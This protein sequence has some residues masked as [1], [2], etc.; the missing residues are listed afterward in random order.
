[1]P[2]LW[3]RPGRFRARPLAGPALMPGGRLAP[4]TLVGLAGCYPQGGYY[5]P[6]G[7]KKG[8]GRQEKAA[9][10]ARSRNRSGTMEG[11]RADPRAAPRAEGGRIPGGSGRIGAG[12]LC[13]PGRR[14]KGP[15]G[16][17]AG[18]WGGSPPKAPAGSKPGQA[19]PSGSM[20][21]RPRRWRPESRSQEGQEAGLGGRA[22]RPAWGPWR[23]LRPQWPTA[24]SATADKRGGPHFLRAEAL[25]AMA[26]RP[27]ETCSS[28]P[29]SDKRAR[30]ALILSSPPVSSKV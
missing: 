9:G 23:G 6:D 7:E 24:P 2:Y 11:R 8:K 25:L 16:I 3:R 27:V 14:R 20:R 4:R 30:A 21:I 12:L 1:M 28:M 5:S 17:R 19:D 15:W 22:K 13:A 18:P 29:N 10:C 26:V